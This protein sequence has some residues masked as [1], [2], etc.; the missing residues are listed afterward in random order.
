MIHKCGGFVIE[1]NAA[2]RRKG[3]ASGSFFSFL[4]LGQLL[5]SRRLAERGLGMDEQ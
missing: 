4:G 2:W 3:A 5:A 1:S